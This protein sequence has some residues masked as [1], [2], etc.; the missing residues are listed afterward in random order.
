MKQ[1]VSLL[2]ALLLA[3]AIAG[4]G[5]EPIEKYDYSR[6]KKVEQYDDLTVYVDTETGIAYGNMSSYPGSLFPLYDKDGNH[7]RPN[8]WRDWSDG[9][10]LY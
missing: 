3:A 2:L 5:I 1:I 8:G 6:F 9:D 10:E 4:C 7:Y